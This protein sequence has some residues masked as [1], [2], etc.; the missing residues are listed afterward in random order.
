MITMTTSTLT[1][2]RAAHSHS[3]LCVPLNRMFD[4]LFNLCEQGERT[5]SAYDWINSN[6]IRVN[7]ASKRRR[8]QKLWEQRTTINRVKTA[9]AAWSVHVS[10]VSS[11][12]SRLKRTSVQ[13]HTRISR[14]KF[15]DGRIF[16]FVCRWNRGNASLWLYRHSWII[17][18]SMTSFNRRCYSLQRIGLPQPSAST[19]WNR[20]KQKNRY[21]FRSRWFSFEIERNIQLNIE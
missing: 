19:S 20:K 16:G 6:R 15:I 7:T 10:A 5:S 2:H 13:M 4:F 14:H 21:S 18:Y 17:M 12:N 11:A 1:E 3:K 9:I 8:K